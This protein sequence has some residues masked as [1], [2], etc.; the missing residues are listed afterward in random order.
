MGCFPLNKECQSCYQFFL[1]FVIW[2]ETVCEW[3]RWGKRRKEKGRER[4]YF[5][6]FLHF[7][8]F[9]ALK[10]WSPVPTSYVTFKET[11]FEVTLILFFRWPQ[12][13]IISSVMVAPPKKKKKLTR[14][15][16]KK[17]FSLI[18]EIFTY[19]DMERSF[20]LILAYTWFVFE[21]M[22]TKNS[23]SYGLSN[24]LYICFYH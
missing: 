17:N 11:N 19:W 7:R 8:R 10:L 21:F 20:L 23:L 6:L 3:E 13:C 9:Q 1:N 2:Q 5:V 24:T 18:E 22:L 15:K 12:F 14:F 16:K 4:Y